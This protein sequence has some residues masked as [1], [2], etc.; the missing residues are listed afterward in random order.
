MMNQIGVTMMLVG[1]LAAA[2]PASA[3]CRRFGTQ[4]ECNVGTNRLVLGTQSAEEPTH[5]ASLPIHS[6]SG[7][8]AFSDGRTTSGH[9]FEIRL[10]DF[11]GSPALCRTI[12]NETYCY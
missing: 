11:A 12:G 3:M 2:S 8:S 5:D 4:V 9:P 1:A 6:L 10:Q 7:V